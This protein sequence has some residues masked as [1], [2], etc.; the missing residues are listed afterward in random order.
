VIDALRTFWRTGV[1][2]RCPECGQTS[3]FRGFYALHERCAVCDTRFETNSG[4][5]LGGSAIGYTIG[6]AVAFALAI[7][8]VQ[9][10]P[11]RQLGLSPMWT[12]A[13]ISLIAT[14][15]GYRPAKALWFA[16]V[17]EWG[18]MA[19]GDGPPTGSPPRAGR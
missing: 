7:I 10:A 17:Y 13:V 14:V 18:F 12:I 2:G 6:A 4:E 8:E 3:M 19:R 1:L 9:W 15:L 11:I 16:L 5:W